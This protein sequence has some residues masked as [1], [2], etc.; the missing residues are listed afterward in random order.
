M[1]E[2]TRTPQ[3][4][5]EALGQPCLPGCL[6]SV[7]PCMSHTCQRP[8]WLPSHRSRELALSLGNGVPGAAPVTT[9]AKR[10][11]QPDAYEFSIRTPVT[12]A[13]WDDYDEARPAALLSGCCLVAWLLVSVPCRLFKL[14]SFQIAVFPRSILMSL[15]CC[16][17][18]LL[19]SVPR[20]LSACPPMPCKASDC[21][22]LQELGGVF[23]RL[24]AALAAGDLPGMADASLRFAFYWCVGRLPEAVLCVPCLSRY[25]CVCAVVCARCC[26]AFG[27]ATCSL[28]SSPC[29]AALRLALRP[30][31]RNLPH[32]TVAF[33]PRLCC[34]LAGTT[35]CPW[36]AAQPSAALCPCWGPSWRRGP[37]CAPPCPRCGV[38]CQVC[39]CDGSGGALARLSGG[40]HLL[41]LRWYCVGDAFVAQAWRLE[42]G[43]VVGSLA[44]RRVLAAWA[45]GVLMPGKAGLPGLSGLIVLA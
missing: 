12:P 41:P 9:K 30:A 16:L 10:Q 45:V 31:A 39:V 13:R 25:V 35:S 34:C 6:H 17:A 32:A 42:R 19:V 29:T 2:W 23:E 28:R 3:T 44:Q 11:R 8:A 1:G 24:T 7:L 43:T 20:C 22:C 37:L 5:M 33:N 38:A 21:L 15:P 36:P 40:W 18:V 14:L 4:N 26:L 27:V